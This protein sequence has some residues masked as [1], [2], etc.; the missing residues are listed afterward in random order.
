MIARP[1]V[2]EPGA[3]SNA[4]QI[5]IAVVLTAIAAIAGRVLYPDGA[6]FDLGIIGGAI[7][8]GEVL[9]LRPPN[10]AAIPLSFG[11][12]LVLGRAGTATQAATTLLVAEFVAAVLR[13]GTNGHTR[14]D[15][16]LQRCLIG[17]A[18]IVAYRSLAELLHDER[19]TWPVVV[20][21]VGAAVAMAGAS[22]LER[23]ITQHKWRP[24]LSGRSADLA[25]VSSGMLMAIGYGGVDGRGR[26]GAWALVLFSIP[27][28]AAWYS[29][30][31]LH[32]AR[33]TYW[34]TIDALSIAPELGGFVPSGHA[35]RVVGL[36]ED[37]ASQLEFSDAELETLRASAYLHH[38]GHV[39]VDRPA[40]STG[41]VDPNDVAHITADMLR[42]TE[43]LRAVG[44]VIEAETRT[45]RSPFVAQPNEFDLAGQVLKVASTYDDITGG[46]AARC[47]TGMTILYSA[48]AY[49]YNPRVI[50]ALEN[51]LKKQGLAVTVGPGM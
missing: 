31:R 37:I 36:C 1:P 2:A 9:L 22:E 17:L 44:D 33:K 34:Q 26:M 5:V 7:V 16:F 43:Q 12:V 21:L 47:N 51:I 13:K 18:G 48:P 41:R 15:L 20:A 49:V 19:G 39:C 45:F 32:S 28:I 24:S 50:A 8:I 30:E 14:I 46:D 6:A 4:L 3:E 25:L 38:L 42:Q 35:E 27:L 11:I 40:D 23:G 29:F 10:R